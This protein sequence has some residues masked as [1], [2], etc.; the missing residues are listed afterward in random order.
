MLTVCI[1]LAKTLINHLT[2][3]SKSRGPSVDAQSLNRAGSVSISLFP[4][5]VACTSFMHVCDQSP[6]RVTMMPSQTLLTLR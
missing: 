2:Y 4:M 6:C 3:K 5:K 1:K